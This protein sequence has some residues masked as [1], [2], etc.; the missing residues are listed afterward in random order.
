MGYHVF[1]SFPCAF[2]KK[3]KKVRLCNS[4]RLPLNLI[5]LCHS[6]TLTWISLIS[7]FGNSI[8]FR[9]FIP[10]SQ[11]RSEICV[12]VPRY[13]LKPG[14]VI[15]V[16]LYSFSRLPRIGGYYSP[17]ADYPFG[18]PN[19]ERLTTNFSHYSPVLLPVSPI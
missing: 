19:T 8:K 5:Q 4:V 1:C 16:Y 17:K 10:M 13:F 9:N 6:G 2:L 7:N 15:C 14:S 18:K 3:Q 11:H 12:Y